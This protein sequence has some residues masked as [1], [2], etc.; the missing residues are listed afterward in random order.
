MTTESYYLFGGLALL[1]L[2]HRYL[3]ESLQKSFE[4]NIR[5]LSRKFV[6][7]PRYSFGLGIFLT[8]ILQSSRLSSLIAVGI[9]QVSQLNRKTISLYIFGASI[10]ATITVWFFLNTHYQYAFLFLVLGV[11]PRLFSNQQR[12]INLGN[13]LSSLGIMS[14]GLLFFKAPL[15]V[16]ENTPYFK[17]TIQYLCFQGTVSVLYALGI[18]TLLAIIFESSNVAAIIIFVCFQTKLFPDSFCLMSIIGANLGGGIVLLLYS[19]KNQRSEQGVGAYHLLFKIFGSMIFIPLILLVKV[20][21]FEHLITIPL[22]HTLFNLITAIVL[23]P[24]YTI[25]DKVIKVLVQEEQVSHS[26]LSHGQD[27]LPASAMIMGNIELKKLSN[28]VV[29]AFKKSKNFLKNKQ[30]PILEYETIKEIEE[31]TDQIHKELTIFLSQLFARSLSHGQVQEAQTIMTISQEFETITDYLERAC[32]YKQRFNF[33]FPDD[34][35]TQDFFEFFEQMEEIFLAVVKK[36]DD[37]ESTIPLDFSV[38]LKEQAEG[39]REAHLHIMSKG[40][41]DPL[42]NMTFA[43]IAISIRRIR[44]PIVNIVKVFEEN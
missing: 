30:N 38:Q 43:D 4:S 2:G 14:L 32:F 29:I 24:V 11:L 25:W 27:L 1:Y 5:D 16:V 8:A 41:T 26:L 42:M 36:I 22:F 23:I 10:G 3:L 17:E 9:G 18:G 40:N 15:V 19:L 6:N 7:F 20:Q 39:I 44:S 12:W 34:Q 13:V 35:M 28:L 31:Q 37:P 33:S 21:P